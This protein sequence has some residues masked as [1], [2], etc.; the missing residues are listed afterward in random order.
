MEIDGVFSGGGI[1]GFALIGALAEIEK[2]GFQFK[3]VAGTSAGSIISALIIAG[4]SSD[5]IERM[6]DDLDLKVFL[7]SR[8]SLIPIAVAKWIFLFWSLGLYKGNELEKWIEARLAARGI[9]TFADVPPLSLRIIASDLTNGRLLVLPDDLPKYQIDPNRFSV[10]KAVRMSCSMPYFFEPVKIGGRGKRN[11]LIVDGGVLSNFP[12][13]LF[14]KD[15]VK[16]TRPVLGVKLSINNNEQPPRRIKN[17][18]QMFEALFETMKDAHDSRYISR[19]HEQNVIFVPTEG[20][21]ATEFELT[22]EGK[23]DLL[24]LGRERAKEFLATWTY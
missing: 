1:K 4:Y 20:V 16:K 24:K 11:N 15:N 19:S 2:Q 17:A 9:R 3:R 12:M 22:E 13:W 21:L 14:D 23:R 18:I 6:M 7:D 8:K 10:A 5:E